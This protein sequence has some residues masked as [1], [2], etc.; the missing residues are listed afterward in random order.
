MI[1][2][3]LSVPSIW[4]LGLGVAWPSGWVHL[5]CW[6]CQL[7]APSPTLTVGWIFVSLSLSFK[8]VRL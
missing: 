8:M 6:T 1:I 7:E 2:T 4:L 3:E 5:A